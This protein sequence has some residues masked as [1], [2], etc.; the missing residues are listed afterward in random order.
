MKRPRLDENQVD[1]SNEVLVEYEEHLL[2]NDL[3]EVE[4]LTSV[5]TPPAVPNES[6]SQQ[7]CLERLDEVG[8]KDFRLKLHQGNLNTT[9][10]NNTPK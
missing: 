9:P 1:R 7:V 3:R 10:E 2:G 5:N 8:E 6:T 4:R